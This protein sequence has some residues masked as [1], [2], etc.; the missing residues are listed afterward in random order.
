MQFFLPHSEPSIAYTD[1][2]FHST[3]GKSVWIGEDKGRSKLI[4]GYFKVLSNEKGTTWKCTCP[5]A[6]P[7][8]MMLTNWLTIRRSWSRESKLDALL[9]IFGK[10]EGRCATSLELKDEFPVDCSMASAE[11]HALWTC[12]V[13]PQAYVWAKKILVLH[14]LSR[15]LVEHVLKVLKAK[16]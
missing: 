2:Q 12:L 6:H 11:A 13:A 15:R 1:T 10:R 16:S 4:F 14:R 7:V 3:V 9:F 8:Q 5:G